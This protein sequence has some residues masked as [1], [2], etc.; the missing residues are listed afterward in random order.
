MSA[1]GA[2][3][4]SE[5]SNARLEWNARR[6]KWWE[7]LSQ[8]CAGPECPHR[9]KLWPSWFRKL[10]GTEFDGRW[11][12]EVGCMKPALTVRV[13]SLLS[14]FLQE[15]PRTYRLPIGL[16]FVN[17]GVI[18]P[19]Q[20]RE[21]LRL[22]RETGQRRIG[23]VLREM[24]LVNEQQLASALGTQWGCP[25]FPLERQPAHLSYGELLP[26]PLLESSRS[27]PAHFSPDGRTLHLAFGERLDHTTLYAIEQMLGC[28]TFACVAPEATVAGILDHFRRTVP[29]QETCFDTIREPREMAWTICSYAEHL[30]SAR[31]AI[32][33]AGSYVW[34]RFFRDSSSRDLLFRILSDPGSSLPT[35]SSATKAF[36]L[37]ADMRKDGVSHAA[38]PV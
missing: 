27:V 17:R 32:V 2:A 38:E 12:C 21:A 30:R 25:V 3:L 16:V 26:L 37:S 10:S 23:D 15:K 36:S 33:R 14:S 13:H 20:L 34:V 18:T 22:Q 11:Y 1:T 28:R 24:H 35:G 7:R 6:E 31:T 19:I 29:R 8:R 9:G 4:V 5:N